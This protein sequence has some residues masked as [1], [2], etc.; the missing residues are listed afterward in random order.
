[1]RGRVASGWPLVT[2]VLLLAGCAIGPDGSASRGQYS[3]KVADAA[4]ASGAPDMALRVSDIILE[5]DPKNIAALV[6]RGD[7]LYALGVD[8]R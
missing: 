8:F 3:V 1:M 4:L 6:S 5:R 2:A 7:A